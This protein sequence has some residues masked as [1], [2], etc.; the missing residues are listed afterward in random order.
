MF[1]YSILRPSQHS[2]YYYDIF[3]QLSRFGVPLEGLHTE[4]GPGVYEAAIVHDEVLAAADKAV[5]LKASV[6]ELAAKHGLMATFMAKWN[7]QL[8]GC[9]G[10]VHQ[11]LWDLQKQSNGTF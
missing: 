3:N 1:G 8:P 2:A 6:K 9:S 4:T 7:E 10:H 11:S 5:L